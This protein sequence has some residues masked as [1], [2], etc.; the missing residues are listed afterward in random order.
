MT[1]ED[2]EQVEKMLRKHCDKLC[3]SA[4]PALVSH[5]HLYS[6]AVKVLERK[7]PNA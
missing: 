6:K 3:F 7:P 5:S 4:Y 2:A 1:L